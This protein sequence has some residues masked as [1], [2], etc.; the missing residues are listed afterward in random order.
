MVSTGKIMVQDGMLRMQH[1]F[2]H[3]IM[4][5]FGQILVIL[6]QM[7]ASLLVMDERHDLLEVQSYHEMLV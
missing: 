1:G 6:V 3:I 7:G 5:V 4:Q 2:V